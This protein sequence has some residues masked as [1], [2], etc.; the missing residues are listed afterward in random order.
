[1][2][3]LLFA[4]ALSAQAYTAMEIP[5]GDPNCWTF[6]VDMNDSGEVCGGWTFGIHGDSDM[7]SFTWRP[8][9]PSLIAWLG[10]PGG[11]NA[12]G[13]VR[14][15]MGG[16]EEV[17]YNARTGESW[18]VTL[19]AMDPD[20]YPNCGSIPVFVPDPPPGPQ[21]AV[22]DL[23]IRGLPCG[24]AVSKIVDSGG[25]LLL[26]QGNQTM[27]VPEGGDGLLMR[28]EVARALVL[29]PVPEPEPATFTCPGNGDTN[30]DGQLDISDVVYTL[31][32][33]YGSGNPPAE[34]TA[35]KS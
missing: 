10:Y 11:I 29:T 31:R 5:V 30:G 18:P 15:T 12:A 32:Y 23:E 26:A 16:Y 22:A 8:G 14:L 34:I 13:L 20:E 3:A 28:L 19:C 25:G 24:M 7:S 17:L 1:M 35:R 33:L 6:A 21:P 2:I 27:Y 9:D 4:A